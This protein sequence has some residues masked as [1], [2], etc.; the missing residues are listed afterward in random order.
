MFS[1]VFLEPPFVHLENGIIVCT[2]KGYLRIKDTIFQT[3]A[4]STHL[5][6]H[7]YFW[8][9]ESL[10][11]NQTLFLGLVLT[12]L[13]KIS[14]QSSAGNIYYIKANRMQVFCQLH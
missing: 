13:G 11:L 2:L 1:A 12:G 10:K 6:S 8:Q 7:N 4:H 5:K 9:V 3:L 14:A